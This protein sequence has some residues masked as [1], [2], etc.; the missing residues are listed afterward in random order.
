[1]NAPMTS[2]PENAVSPADQLRAAKLTMDDHIFRWFNQRY[3]DLMAECLRDYPDDDPS[4]A[5]LCEADRAIALASSTPTERD[6][7][8]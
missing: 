4:Y 5:T 8:G 7:R 2:T 3:P 1:M 6:D